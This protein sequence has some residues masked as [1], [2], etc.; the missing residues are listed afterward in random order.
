MKITAGILTNP[1]YILI[2]SFWGGI[3]Q[4]ITKL[5]SLKVT[6]E[7]SVTLQIKTKYMNYGYIRYVDDICI[8]QHESILYNIVSI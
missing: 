8:V 4:Q 3:G 7:R 5:Q 1:H 6:F 2:Q